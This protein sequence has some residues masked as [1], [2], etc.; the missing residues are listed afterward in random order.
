MGNRQ[1]GTTKLSY[2]KEY[3]EGPTNTQY[4]GAIFDWSDPGDA[5][6]Y[7]Q[8]GLAAFTIQAAVS[9]TP[10]LPPAIFEPDF[11]KDEVLRYAKLSQ[12]AYEPYSVVEQ[13]LPDYNLVAEMQIY[14]PNTDTN[15]FI[16]SD[17]SCIV[18]AFRGTNSWTN[19]LTDTWFVR[20]PI[21]PGSETF[22]HKGF[23]TAFN[24]VYGSIE[25][26]LKPCLG[27][28]K[29]FVTGHSLGGALATLLTYRISLAHGNSQPI[30][31][32][33]G[34]PPVGDIDL[35]TYFRGME[36]NT[37]TIQ[38]DPFSSGKLILLGEWAGWYKPDL[39]K[40]L[41]QA[42]GHRIANYIEQLENLP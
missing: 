38:N 25:A 17:D 40:Y 36:S 2:I 34:C 19:F 5:Y 35:A 37:I 10:E 11:D 30:Q 28:K 22:A 32:V 16:A 15:G 13:Q 26:K 12:L 3:R 29:L 39:V 41:P 20:M 18:V 31:Y 23:L 1:E 33:Y 9:A 8:I 24:A 6:Q 21:V 4:V 7:V 27:K 42:A 14:D